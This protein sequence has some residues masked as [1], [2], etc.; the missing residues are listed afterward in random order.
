[1]TQGRKMQAGLHHIIQELGLLLGIDADHHPALCFPKEE[2]ITTDLSRR[3]DIEAQSSGQGTFN[4][5][6][7]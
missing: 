4:Q 7:K 6:H 3:S 2:G 5:G 1:M